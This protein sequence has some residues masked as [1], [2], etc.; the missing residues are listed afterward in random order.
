MQAS[1]GFTTY[2]SRAEVSLEAK[3]ISE[4]PDFYQRQLFISIFQAN[5]QVTVLTNK[6]LSLGSVSS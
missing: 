6:N 3:H 2:S 1:L 5:K 4:H